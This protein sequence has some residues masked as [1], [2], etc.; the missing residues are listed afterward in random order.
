MIFLP[1]LIYMLFLF[2]DY[3]AI[4]AI[5]DSFISFFFHYGLPPF[6]AFS[7]DC[8]F[9]DYATYYFLI[10]TAAW[11]TPFSL[12]SSLYAAAFARIAAYCHTPLLARL[13]SLIIADNI[14]DYATPIAASLFHYHGDITTPATM[15]IANIIDAAHDWFAIFIYFQDMIRRFSL[16]FDTVTYSHL[17]FSFTISPDYRFSS[18]C[19]ADFAIYLYFHAIS[20]F[21][22][23]FLIIFRFSFW[24]TFSMFVFTMFAAY[25]FLILRQRLWYLLAI[26]HYISLP[27][28]ILSS[29]LFCCL[30]YYAAFRI[31]YC[32]HVLIV[33]RLFFRRC[34]VVDTGADAI[35]HY[36]IFS[37]IIAISRHYAAYH[38]FDIDDCHYA[39]SL[40]RHFVLRYCYYAHYSYY[41]YLSIGC[42]RCC[43]LTLIDIFFSAA[44]M[45]FIISLFCF[46]WYYAWLLMSLR[47]WL[48]CC[49]PPHAIAIFAAFTHTFAT[50]SFLLHFFCFA[51]ASL[52]PLRCHT[53]YCWLPTGYAFK[54]LRFFCFSFA[55]SIIVIFFTS[56]FGIITF[57]PCR[58]FRYFMPR[59]LPYVI[60]G[61]FSP[62][63]TL[64]H[65]WCRH[66]PLTLLLLR[67]YAIDFFFTRCLRHAIDF[68]T[69]V[70]SL[71]RRWSFRFFFHLIAKVTAAI[72][73]I[74]WA[75]ILFRRCLHCHSAAILRRWL[76]A[77]NLVVTLRDSVHFSRDALSPI[78]IISL[79]YITEAAATTMLWYAAA[80]IFHLMPVASA[81]LRFTGFFA[82]AASAADWFR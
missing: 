23:F 14:D 62:A 48:R 71:M 63:V 32:L 44:T 8:L 74:S 82:R 27:V 66:T 55:I 79:R 68:F 30:R 78:P 42:Y 41:W 26:Y 2:I 7:Y 21:L 54:M 34:H 65:A 46:H 15:P 20:L 28:I 29:P 45:P 37:L 12:L 36:L 52:M 72:I 38:Y 4:S 1:W 10:I 50:F 5:I 9:A 81:M 35:I 33:F 76:S 61:F 25:C 49:S 77:W 47:H 11:F 43:L 53:P 70:V 58:L 75:S 3:F 17:R 69:P 60:A 59:C 6:F 18:R 80:S 73:I 31:W 56:Y 67:H 64:F 57:T 24:F 22:F 13:L 16:Y 51:Y 40:C 19:F 39:V